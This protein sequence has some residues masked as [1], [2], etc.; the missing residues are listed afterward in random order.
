MKHQI[1][2]FTNNHIIKGTNDNLNDSYLNQSDQTKFKDNFY[3]NSLNNQM[4]EKLLVNSSIIS[5]AENQSHKN[6]SIKINRKNENNLSYSNQNQ[7][8]FT[9]KLNFTSSN[10]IHD[11]TMNQPEKIL[12][13]Q[14]S[15]S[16]NNSQVNILQSQNISQNRKA[17]IILPFDKKKRAKEKN[18]KPSKKNGRTKTQTQSSTN[19][20]ESDEIFFDDFE[21]DLV[22]NLNANTNDKYLTDKYFS[23]NNTILNIVDTYNNNC[24]NLVSNFNSFKEIS[25]PLIQGYFKSE[26]SEIIFDGMMNLKGKTA[27]KFHFSNCKLKKFHIM[28]YGQEF[29]Y[30]I[31]NLSLNQKCLVKNQK[32]Y[33][34]NSDSSDCI[35]I[36]ILLGI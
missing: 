18:K 12:F 1:N 24:D 7:H 20:S 27:F 21:E 33:E 23:D 6:G 26:S 13:S 36:Y 16:A 17:D 28:Y 3:L 35:G 25:Q 30:S 9:N 5:R 29:K 22:D 10:L 4:S 31:E 19:D 15:I 14:S 8:S 11:R 34:I 2:Y 32:M